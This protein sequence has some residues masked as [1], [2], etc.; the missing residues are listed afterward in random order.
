MLNPELL[1]MLCCPIGKADLKLDDD[2]LVCT[3]C[4][5]KFSIKEGIP[6]LLLEEAILPEGVKDINDLDCKKDHT[7]PY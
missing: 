2:F 7:P 6:V 5:V 4:G 3:R 1:K